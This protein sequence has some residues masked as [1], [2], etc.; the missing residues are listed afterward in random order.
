MQNQRKPCG[1][2]PF[3]SGLDSDGRRASLGVILLGLGRY[4]N[5]RTSLSGTNGQNAV[6]GNAG[7]RAARLAPLNITADDALASDGSGKRL[8][9]ALLL[10]FFAGAQIFKNN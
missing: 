8:R 5:T 10:P 4:G 6:F 7:F 3:N 2:S 1:L 9:T